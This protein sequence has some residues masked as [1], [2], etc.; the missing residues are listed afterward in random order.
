MNKRRHRQITATRLTRQQV[1]T[2]PRLK[3]NLSGPIE[4]HSQRNSNLRG[5]PGLGLSYQRCRVGGT[6]RPGLSLATVGTA[7]LGQDSESASRIAYVQ[8]L[9]RLLQ[10]CSGFKTSTTSPFLSQLAY[11]KPFLEALWRQTLVLLIN[12]TDDEELTLMCT[13]IFCD[14]F[15][16]HLISLSDKTFYSTT[17][18]IQIQQFWQSM[19]SST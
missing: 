13:T 9:G 2:V 8:L 19:L 6:I 17:R 5:S 7:V 16:H 4:S 10:G 1:Q 15:A 12:G 14:V 3:S 18:P 11:S